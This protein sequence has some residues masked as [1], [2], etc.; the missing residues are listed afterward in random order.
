MYTCINYYSYPE[1]TRNKKIKA[2]RDANNK[3]ESNSLT[4]DQ[5]CAPLEQD[6]E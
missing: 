3:T 4:I 5:K 6:I 2:H 1:C